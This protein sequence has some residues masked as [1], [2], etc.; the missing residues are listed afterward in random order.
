MGQPVLSTTERLRPDLPLR[1]D[2]CRPQ[3]RTCHGHAWIGWSWTQRRRDGGRTPKF[4]TVAADGLVASDP[5]N[6]NQLTLD[7]TVSSYKLPLRAQAR[8]TVAMARYGYI[9]RASRMLWTLVMV[10]GFAFAAEA[11]T[12]ISLESSVE[13]A[14]PPAR[15]LAMIPGSNH[16]VAERRAG[17][18]FL[19]TPPGDYVLMVIPRGTGALP[20]EMGR[21]EHQGP[22]PDRIETRGLGETQ[23][24]AAELTD[25]GHDNPQDR[26][27]NCRVEIRIV[28]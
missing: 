14:E 3:E 20:V 16:F 11:R 7:A 21:V 6:V 5:S 10:S 27:R 28:K 26:Q 9:L 13:D 25:D 4:E 23:P 24:V 18:G 8:G 15:W 19:E 12:G 1:C 22:A 2:R 17:W